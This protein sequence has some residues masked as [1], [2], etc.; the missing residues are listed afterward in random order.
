MTE[1]HRHLLYR[2]ASLVHPIAP[3]CSKIVESVESASARRL[4]SNIPHRT[5]FYFLQSLRV[6]R[7][8]PPLVLVLAEEKDRVGVIQPAVF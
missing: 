1:K 8:L 3:H 4:H 7:P 6:D 2:G 5:F